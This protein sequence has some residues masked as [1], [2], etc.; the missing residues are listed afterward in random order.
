MNITDQTLKANGFVHREELDYSFRRKSKNV[1]RRAFVRY[2]QGED[3][4]YL[5]RTESGAT[6]GKMNNIR[7]RICQKYK[8]VSS[9]EEL[10]NAL[11]EWKD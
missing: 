9:G 8:H 4:I 3:P 7:S 2:R 11:E 10:V 6:I 1:V 5:Y